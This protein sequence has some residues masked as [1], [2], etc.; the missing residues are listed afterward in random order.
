MPLNGQKL[1]EQELL[2]LALR[3]SATGRH[4]LAIEK[5]KSLIELDPNHAHALHM[6]A[7]EHAQIGLLPRAIS[8]FEKALAV[9][10]ELH[11][12]R[13]Q[14]GLAHYALS[15]LASAEA[16]WQPLKTLGEHHTLPLYATGLIQIL[17]EEFE[18]AVRSLEMALTAEPEIP[19]LRKD[20][21]RSVE[22]ARSQLSN[23]AKT[24]PQS[25]DMSKVLASRYGTAANSEDDAP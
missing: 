20:I 14:M 11:V 6:L 1:D 5:L 4:D 8:E 3:D 15:D 13:F 12:A 22:R 10:P 24:G 18:Q 23:D 25:G 19:S 17:R 21:A 9:D 16:A 7:A 2:A